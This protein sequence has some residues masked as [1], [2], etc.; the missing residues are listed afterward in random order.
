LSF[1]ESESAHWSPPR[2]RGDPGDGRGR[3][4]RRES[5]RLPPDAGSLVLR[6]RKERGTVGC[7]V[8]LTPLS[9]A[10]VVYL[11]L[12]REFPVYY[13]RVIVRYSATRRTHGSS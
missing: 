8:R 4:R 3:T 5:T 6:S 7:F 12:M 2:S 1:A 13:F 9:D 11:A 10:R